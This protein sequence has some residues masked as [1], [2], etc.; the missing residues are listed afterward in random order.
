MSD[1]D[2]PQATAST[3]TQVGQATARA[4]FIDCSI[5]NR[6]SVPSI[7]CCIVRTVVRQFGGHS[8]SGAPHSHQNRGF[9]FF[10]GLSRRS[11]DEI[12]VP[13]DK[14]SDPR[15]RSRRPGIY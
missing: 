1:P 6:P 9:G 15:T 5:M 4:I 8:S 12:H 7:A 10:D 11:K 3:M 2:I 13:D 14:D